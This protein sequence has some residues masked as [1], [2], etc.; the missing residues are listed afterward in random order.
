M[1]CI[2]KQ[3]TKTLLEPHWVPI[4]F[5]KS[6]EDTSQL[7][8]PES[9]RSFNE[10]V[11]QAIDETL[12]ELVGSRAEAVYLHLKYKFGV[13]RNELPYRI[14]TLCY[15]LEYAFGVKAA[16]VVERRVVK[17]LFYRIRLPFNDQEGLTLGDFLKLAKETISSDNRYVT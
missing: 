16:H 3:K 5:N 2:M 6:I 8:A 7:P 10:I 14:D 12:K 4:E 11:C 17:K 9:V 15:V 1:C 13:D